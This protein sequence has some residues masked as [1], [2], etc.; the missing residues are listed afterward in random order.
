MDYVDYNLGPEPIH[1]TSRAQRAAI[2]KERGLREAIWHI[3]MPGSDKSPHTRSWDTPCA[4]TMEQA[5]IL[6]SRQGQ[7]RDPDAGRLETLRTGWEYN[8]VKAVV[9]A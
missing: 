7:G 4:Y 5:R 2:M 9:K 6:V 3:P 1:I 8:P